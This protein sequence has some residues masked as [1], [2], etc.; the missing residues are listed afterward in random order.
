MGSNHRST[1]R[2]AAINAG[3]SLV[4]VLDLATPYKWTPGR[5][6]CESTD[7]WSFVPVHGYSD[8]WDVDGKDKVFAF[9]NRRR[10][11]RTRAAELISAEPAS[12]A[13]ALD[14][15]SPAGTAAAVIS[16][17]APSAIADPVACQIAESTAVAATD[18][19]PTAERQTHGPAAGS[20]PVPTAGSSASAE[21][22]VQV[23]A[24]LPAADTSSLRSVRYCDDIMYYIV[25][26]DDYTL[27]SPPLPVRLSR[28]K[29]LMKSIRKLIRS[30]FSSQQDRYY[31]RFI[32]T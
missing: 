27:P 16:L 7:W 24:G 26:N 8:D 5:S 6:T 21:L 13:S 23:P 19:P 25:F 2:R 10:T 9:Y 22:I 12:S 32:H 31:R 30:L 18:T 11:P 17:D 28:W 3:R 1:A 4:D 14:T 29:R 20:A 15:P